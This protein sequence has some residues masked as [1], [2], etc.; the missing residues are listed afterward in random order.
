MRPLSFF[1]V[2]PKPRP[3]FPGAPKP[4]PFFPVAL[5]ALLAL[6]TTMF[7]CSK[8]TSPTQPAAASS[9]DQ[10][11]QMLGEILYSEITSTTTPSRPSDID[12]TPAYNKYQEALN[13]DPNNANANLG[14]GVLNLLSLSKDTEV[15]AAFDEWQTYLLSKKVPFQTSAAQRT[16]QM[17]VPLGLT[18]A[19]LAFALPLE[20]G[21]RTALGLARPAVAATT[22][23]LARAQ[24]ILHDRVLP[25]LVQTVARLDKVVAAPAYVFW[26][27][28]RMQG[29]NSASPIEVDH[30]DFL[31][32]RASAHLLMGLCEMAVAYDVN[33]T[34]YDSTTLVNNFKSGSAWLSLTSDGAYQLADAQ[35]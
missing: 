19:D 34:A 14:V 11:N 24:A 7:G 3:S 30:T 17:G 18:S 9:V 6:S 23:Q 31:A 28:P 22:P 12:F 26:V 32:L 21:P 15:N 4:L 10:A 2:A 13:S 1:P 27:T 29:D 5:L 35:S 16:S 33:F 8:S 20:M 25:R